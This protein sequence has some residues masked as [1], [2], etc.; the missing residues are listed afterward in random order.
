MSTIK[1][2][3]FGSLVIFSAGMNQGC[4]NYFDDLV[5]N[6]NLVQTPPINS[7]LATNTFKAGLNNQRV[8][9]FTSYFVQYLA[10][11]TASGVS[12]TYQIADYSVAWNN[13]YWALADLHDF[14]VAAEAIGATNHLGVANVLFVYHLA[15]LNDVWGSVPLSDAFATNGSLSPA[16]DSDEEIYVACMNYIDEAIELLSTE[17]G[18]DLGAE[19]DVI[20]RGNKEA[21]LK[22]AYALKARLLNKVS[23]KTSYDPQAVLSATSQAYSSNADDAGMALFNGNN[24]WAQIA[25]GNASALLGGW[26]SDQFINHLNGTAYGV[27][28]PRIGRITDRTVNGDYVGTRNGEGNRPVYDSN[29]DLVSNTVKDECYISINS[30]LT[31]QTSPITLV[32]YA[33]LRFVEAEAALRSGDRTR[34]Y[35]AYLSGIQAHMDKLGVPTAEASAYINNPVVSVGATQLN[36][37][38][39]FKEKYVVTYLNPEAWNDARR[40]DYN[41]AGW[42]LPLN[43]VLDEEI[44]QAAYP[45]DEL[46]RNSNVPVQNALS[47]R[48]WFDQP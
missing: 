45:Q 2:I 7:F 43:V 46:N 35:E 1:K 27:V 28:D 15:M 4:K 33:E 39:I 18:L 24:P 8:A 10:N 5:E 40:Y 29:G 13:T 44:R 31:S 30:P 38:L 36:L 37:D 19:Q 47:D 14:Q 25:I 17:G 11:P 26:L 22:T 42:R 16:Y 9:N 34:A 3:I 48:L 41:Y 21:W 6:P 23:K 20:H 32:S 12:D